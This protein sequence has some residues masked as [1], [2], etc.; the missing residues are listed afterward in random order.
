MAARVF[1]AAR[2]FVAAVEE[3][4]VLGQPLV[5]TPYAADRRTYR[6]PYQLLYT[7]PAGRAGLGTRWELAPGALPV[8]GVEWLHPIPDMDLTSLAIRLPTSQRPLV[9][10][11]IQQAAPAPR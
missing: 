8:D 11:I 10:S 1:P 6:G 4:G 2:T 5:H 7:T 3:E 9:A